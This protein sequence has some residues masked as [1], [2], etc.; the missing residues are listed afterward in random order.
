MSGFAAKFTYVAKDNTVE[1]IY[2]GNQSAQVYEYTVK[3]GVLSLKDKDTG[4]TIDYKK[5]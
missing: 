1:I 4:T 5:K 3:D 2:D